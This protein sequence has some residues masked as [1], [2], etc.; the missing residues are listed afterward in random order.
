MHD[1]GSSGS[2]GGWRMIDVGMETDEGKRDDGGIEIQVVL[3]RQR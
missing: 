1:R 2:D 3:R